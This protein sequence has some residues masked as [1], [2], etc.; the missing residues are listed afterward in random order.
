MGILLHMPKIDY[1]SIKTMA[2]PSYIE[3]NEQL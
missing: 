3:M 1:T 2:Q